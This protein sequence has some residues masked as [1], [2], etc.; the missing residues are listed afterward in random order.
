[1]ADRLLKQD[2]IEMLRRALLEWGGPARCSD[3]LAVGMGF[4]GWE[5][6]LG[7]CGELRRALE[8]GVPLPPADWARVLLATEIVFISDLAG[9]GLE[10]STTTGLEDESTLQTLRSIQRKLADTVGSFHGRTPDA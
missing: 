7:R 1:M 4:A 8:E 5:D 9:S 2:E 10:W 6:L 3:Q